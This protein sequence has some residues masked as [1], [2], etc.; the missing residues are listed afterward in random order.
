VTSRRKFLRAA[1]AAAAAAQW[2]RVASSQAK[3]AVKP[4]PGILVNDVHSQLNSTRVYRIASPTGVDSVRALLSSARKEKRPVC[5]AGGRHAMGG[6]QFCA[7]ALMLDIRKM[8]RVLAFDPVAGRLEVESGIQWP[9]ILSFLQNAQRGIDKPWAFAQKQTGADRLTIGGS[10]SANIHG[11]GLALPP[12]IN[13]VESFKLIDARGNLVNCSREENADLFRLAIGGYGLFGFIYSAT[14]RL[15]PR[16]KLERVAEVREIAGLAEAFAE[17]IR[18]GFTYGDFQYAIDEKSD[19]FLKRGVFCTYRPVEDERPMPALQRELSEGEWT[20]LLFLAHTQKSEAFKRYASHYVA[21]N[22]QLYWSDEQQMSTYPEEYHRSI[23]RMT[24]AA[25]KAT[26][27]ICEI[28]CERP[29]LERF[30]G[31]VRDYAR[32]EGVSII[33]GTVRLIEEDKESFLAWAKKPW[34]C[35]IFNLHIE[36]TTGGM[37]RGGDALRRLI[38]IGLRHGGSYYPT[39]HR[40]ALRRQVDACY[41]R[42]PEFLKLKRKYDR[43]EL[44]QSEWYRHYKR[45]YFPEK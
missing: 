10:L 32:R 22:G 5:I 1:A 13:D 37:I 8:N 39:Y 35:V 43:D 25:S 45:M 36:H 24:D 19:D 41:P 11:R 28:Y 15:V 31:E 33:Y 14:L 21:T 26:E 42:M 34:A 7:D 9:D 6:Q 18:D 27:A 23:D 16:R 40:Y 17:R 38:D 2:P 12:F 4:P 30:M 44:F 20:E 3:K 29:A